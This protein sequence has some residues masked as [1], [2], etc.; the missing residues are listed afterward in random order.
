VAERRYGPG[1]AP[2]R[3]PDP[4]HGAGRRPAGG[5]RAQR[6]AAQRR[7]NLRLLALAGVALV[8]LVVVLVVV[9]AGGGGGKRHRSAA[10]PP[11]R[12]QATLLLMV[13]GADGTAVESALLAHDP[14]TRRGAVVLVPST[15]VA[16]VPGRGQLAFGQT[17]TLGASQLPAETLGDVMGVTVD[18][19]V[20]VDASGLAALVDRVGGV[21]VDQVDTDVVVA[22]SGNTERVLV[23]KGGRQRLSGAQ[24]VGY[25]TYRGAGENEQARLARFTAVL[26][27]LVRALPADA[28]G[29]AAALRSLGPRLSAT[30]PVA[31]V[32]A[33]LAGLRA[34]DA[35]DDL[36]FE[37]LPVQAA[38]TGD[39]VLTPQPDQVRQLVR[40]YLAA[41]IPS[42]R[43]AGHNRVIVVN[44]TGALGLGGTA[45]SRLDRA[46]LVFVHSENQQG[47][48]FRHKPSVVLVPDDST[49]SHQMGHRVAVAL[50]L[51]D[52]DIA[53]DSQPTAA[54]DVVVI[55]GA[56]YRP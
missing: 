7:R 4:G 46:G 14:S 2:R 20:V 34:D 15:M 28:A 33:V 48:S 56:D 27:G 49:A 22:G 52:R 40:R 55:L 29:D 42:G 26:T 37:T 17:P 1:P 19:T 11:G 13:R 51:P 8:V 50:G 35:A 41:S 31:R 44:G 12:T 5:R 23:A 39:D 18:G 16:D 47:F 10:K 36:P 24:A 21:E 30:V 54:A 53:I 38:G 3:R 6:R 25:A 45:H 32:A 9:L 43:A